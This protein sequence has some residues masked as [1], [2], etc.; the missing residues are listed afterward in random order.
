MAGLMGVVFFRA[1]AGAGLALGVILT[2]VLVVISVIDLD[3]RII[4]D[5]FSLGLLWTALVVSPLNTRL[6]MSG[7][8]RAL[9]AGLGAGVGFASAWLMAVAGR[10]IFRREALG[11]GDV[12]LLAAL[13]AFLGGQGVLTTWFLASIFGSLFF[14]A[15]KCR[16][17]LDWGA[18]LPFGPFLAAGAWAHWAWPDFF[19]RWWGF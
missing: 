3:W 13:G 9:S 12:K 15:L 8:D 18:Y 6:G 5:V 17:K 14:V 1:G 7:L 16:R 19:A 11:G 10:R 2:F 4:P